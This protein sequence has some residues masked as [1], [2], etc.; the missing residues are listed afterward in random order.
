MKDSIQLAEAAAEPW[1]PLYEGHIDAGGREV[2][3]RLKPGWTAADHEGPT[4]YRHSGGRWLVREQP[5]VR[6]ADQVECLPGCGLLLGMLPGALLADVGNLEEIW[7]QPQDLHEAGD[8]LFWELERRAWRAADEEHPVAALVLEPPDCFTENALTAQKVA[9]VNERDVLEI[10]R[11]LCEARGVDVV[12]DLALTVTDEDTNTRCHTLHPTRSL[13][14][15][16][17]L[18]KY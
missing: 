7:L 11:F 1:A 6:H 9:P 5:G 3:C 14:I 4:R 10:G 16:A 18:S 2:L 8:P 17:W 15:L 12:R 13:S